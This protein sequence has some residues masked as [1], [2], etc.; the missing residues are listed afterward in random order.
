MI[1]TT[2]HE[3][4]VDMHCRLPRLT[5][6]RA[7]KV[8]RHWDHMDNGAQPSYDTSECC[9]RFDW[10]V[11]I[12]QLEQQMWNAGHDFRQAI[13]AICAR[14]IVG[15]LNSCADEIREGPS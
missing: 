2:S 12:V 11:T 7:N 10:A 13:H 1:G 5:V 14:H 6:D 8:A 9:E 4:L 15:F 3:V